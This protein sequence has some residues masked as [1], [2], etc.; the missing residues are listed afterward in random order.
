MATENDVD[1]ADL[2]ETVAD[3]LDVDPEALTDEAHFIDDLGVDSLV[4]LEL[5]VTL[6]RTYRVKV[7]EAEM[8]QMR[9]FPDVRDLVRSKLSN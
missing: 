1:E 3:A 2:R 8:A 4:A 6:E 9:R 5:A 7:A